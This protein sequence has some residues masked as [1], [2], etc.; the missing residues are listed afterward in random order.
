MFRII[1]GKPRRKANAVT[2]QPKLLF[3]EQPLLDIIIFFMGATTVFI[4]NS[5]RP[6][7]IGT[8]HIIRLCCFKIIHHFIKKSCNLPLTNGDTQQR[9]NEI[10]AYHIIQSFSPDDKITPEEAHKIGMEFME[11]L[12]SDR[13]AFV[14]ATHIDKNHIH[15][16]FAICS[17][18]RAM[19][20]R[21]LYD[22]LSLLHKMQKS[23]TKSAAKT[24]FMSWIRSTE[25]QRPTRNGLRIKPHRQ[26]PKK[27]SF[28]NLSTR[29]FLNQIVSRIS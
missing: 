18:P 25:N 4:R 5:H 6:D 8:T 23:T 10:T 17:A 13:F 24:V 29:L 16:H 21:K 19:T 12:F 15:N 14:C 7:G 28:G 11:K 20:G 26:A 2:Q 3:G 27:H 22:D 1:D 9:K